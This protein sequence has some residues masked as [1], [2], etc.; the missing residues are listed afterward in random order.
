MLNGHEV[1]V[2]GIFYG[3]VYSASIPHNNCLLYGIIEYIVFEKKE[4]TKIGIRLQNDNCKLH[5]FFK[6]IR[7]N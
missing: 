5:Y 1:S 7:L 6:E 4:V 3:E 2:G